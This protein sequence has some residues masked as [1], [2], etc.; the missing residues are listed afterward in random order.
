MGT[1]TCRQDTGALPPRNRLAYWFIRCRKAGMFFSSMVKPAASS[2]PPKPSSRSEQASRAANRLNPPQLRQEPLPVPPDR[3]IIKLGQAYFSERREA[4]MPTTP[5][6]QVSE[7]S[8]RA[9][10]SWGGVSSI[11]STAWE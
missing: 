2:W 7:A 8:T 5:W 9:L 1:S 11:C 10:R 3:W 4:T 6:C